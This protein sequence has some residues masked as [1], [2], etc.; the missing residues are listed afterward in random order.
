MEDFFPTLPKIKLTYGKRGKKGKQDSIRLASFWP[1]K[2]QIVMHPFLLAEG[3]PDAY[4]EYLLFHE[5]CHAYMIFTGQ[6]ENTRQHGPEF[7]NLESKFPQINEARR[8]ENNHL[9]KFLEKQFYL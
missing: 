5:L 7:K 4:I 2:K 1:H 8:W 3:V 9:Q 6:S